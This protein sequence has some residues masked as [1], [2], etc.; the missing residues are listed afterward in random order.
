MSISLTFPTVDDITTELKKLGHGALLYKVNIL[1]AFRHIKVDPGDFDLLCLEWQGHYVNICI[2]F[3]TRPGSQI[4]LHLSNG[5]TYIICQKGFTIID[6]TDN[7]A[8]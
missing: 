7:Y 8:C 5:I 4:F 6:S 1:C 3:G 2:P